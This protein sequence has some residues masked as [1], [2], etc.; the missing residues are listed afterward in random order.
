MHFPS[1]EIP[2]ITE[3]QEQLLEIFVCAVFVA[4]RVVDDGVD[5]WLWNA[6]QQFW[7]MVA[8]IVVVDHLL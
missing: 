2:P 6:A 8:A 4:Y 3:L 1:T 5:N 7:H